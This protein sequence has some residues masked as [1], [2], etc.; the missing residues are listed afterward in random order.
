MLRSRDV[1]PVLEAE[2]P[3]CGPG[4]DGVADTDPD[5]KREL[6][7]I[8]GLVVVGPGGLGRDLPGV[9]EMERVEVLAPGDARRFAGVA[10]RDPPGL[11]D[12]RPDCAPLLDPASSRLVSRRPE[13]RCG[14]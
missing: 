7:A 5:G 4:N 6:V 9:R 3:R 10:P 2:L 14:R 1:V 11:G 12:E 13:L 8:R